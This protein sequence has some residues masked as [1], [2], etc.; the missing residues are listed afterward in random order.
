MSTASSISSSDLF[1]TSNSGINISNL[2]NSFAFDFWAMDADLK[3][4][5]Q[6]R[7]SLNKWG[8]VLGKQIEDLNI[9][10]TLQSVWKEQALK[11]L[12]GEVVRS[13]YTAAENNEELYFEST[14]SPVTLDG[15][16]IGIM[17]ITQDISRFKRA[18]QI[19]AK[20]KAEISDANTALKVLLKKRETDKINIENKIISNLHALV[21][22]LLDELAMEAS[23]T[24][25]PLLGEMKTAL[26]E[27]CSSFS[28]DLK[29]LNLTATQIQVANHIKSGKTTKE[30][31]EIMGVAP[32]T[33]NTHR[34]QIRK[35]SG[36][37]N[38]KVSLKSF[39]SS[40]S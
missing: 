35:K 40:L 31:A 15:K 11:S 23:E 14:I 32:S 19:Q 16:N 37:Q 24:Q 1:H 36:L 25:K 21:F 38:Q 13:I 34:A 22:P 28:R 9:S 26:A 30:I 7:H 6:N 12:N 29:H 27:I 18:E 2:I 8:D 5:F 20:Q 4:V 39:L 33:V 17:G 3:Y 10:R